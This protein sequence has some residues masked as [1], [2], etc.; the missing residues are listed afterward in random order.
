MAGKIVIKK[1]NG[2]SHTVIVCAISLFLVLAVAGYVYWGKSDF[3]VQFSDDGVEL[4]R[5]YTTSNEEEAADLLVRYA[6][7]Q[8]IFHEHHGYYA[9]NPMELIFI[10][11]GQLTII[12]EDLLLLEEISDPNISFSNY[13]YVPVEKH[14]GG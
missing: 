12:D 6:A 10:K 4:K 8:K 11:D 2:S 13:Y 3:Y 1:R 9:K 14:G 7:A 5:G